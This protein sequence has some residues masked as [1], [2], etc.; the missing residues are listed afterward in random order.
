M[1]SNEVRQFEVRDEDRIM[2]LLV[3]HPTGRQQ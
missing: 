1:T 3:L 2:Q